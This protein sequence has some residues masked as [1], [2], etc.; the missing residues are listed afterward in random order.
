MNA[1][2]ETLLSDPTI[3]RFHPPYKTVSALCQRWAREV[4]SNPTGLHAL[5]NR[6]THKPLGPAFPSVIHTRRIR[7]NK[8]ALLQ[9]NARF[10]VISTFA[11]GGGS[12]VGYSLAGGQV[13]LAIEF[14]PEAARAYRS[15]FPACEVLCQDIREISDDRRRTVALLRSVGLKPGEVD[16]L[17]G[18][19]PCSE[20]SVAGRGLSDQTRSKAYSDVKQAGIAMLPFDLV[21]LIEKVRPKIVIIE[22]V[23][24]I[25]HKGKQHVLNNLLRALRHPRAPLNERRGYFAGYRILSAADYGTPQKRRRLFIIGVRCDVGE[26]TGI[27]DDDKVS[28]LFPSANSGEIS[29]REALAGLRQAESDITPWQKAS[30]PFSI[31]RLIRLLPKNPTRHIGLAHVDR[32]YRNGS[33]FSLVRSAWDLPAPTL[34]VMGQGPNALGGVLHPEEDRKFTLPELKRLTGLPDD[35]VLTGTLAQGA[36]R[37][38]RMV[39]PLMIKAIAESVYQ[40]VLLPYRERNDAAA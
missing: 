14:V 36:E 5:L 11:G 35:Y 21:D 29:I 37:I 13:K 9:Q 40:R 27:D 2:F 32:A 28:L 15:N 17:D 24:G 18:S 30:M 4:K 12:S 25:T 16:V 33:N 8:C 26:A 7:W 22:N 31:G 38:C 20:F 23:P 3:N 1:L 10:N 19:P 34:T 6:P 39:P